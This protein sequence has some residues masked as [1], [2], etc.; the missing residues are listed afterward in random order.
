M[1]QDVHMASRL[2]V[3]TALVLA[4]I[5][6]GAMW[7]VVP[8]VLALLLGWDVA[9]ATYIVWSIVLGRLLDADM[10]AQIAV[11]EDPG[12]ATMDAI[13]LGAAAASVGAVVALIAI[14][15]PGSAVTNQVAVVVSVVSLALSWALVHVLYTGRYARLY[16][17]PPVGGVEFN[18]DEP[19]S[20]ADFAY[21]AFTIGM[22]YQVS[23]TALRSSLIRRTALW[24][25]LL[26]YLL[27]AGII[28][29][30]INLL[31]GLTR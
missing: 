12:R 10:T 3:V 6:F 15:G 17:T 5:A 27:G 16:Y 4:L 20:Y 25:A 22:T 26:S 9:A 18:T 19:P 11:R 1:A 24:H 23:D 7:W 8:P 2:R 28:A 29:S 31:V 21:L 13:L 30:T 14:A